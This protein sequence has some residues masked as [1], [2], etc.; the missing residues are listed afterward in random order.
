[1]SVYKIKV[2]KELKKYNLCY[3]LTVVLM[4]IGMVFLLLQ[5]TKE[6]ILNI[7]G[8]LHTTLTFI[9]ISYTPLLNFTEK[10]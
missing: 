10:G 2:F 5:I 3:L 7:G 9:H 1:M 4:K 8:P 6:Y